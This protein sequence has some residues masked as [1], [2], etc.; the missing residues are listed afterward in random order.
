MEDIPCAHDVEFLEFT[1]FGTRL[2]S[3]ASS[4]AIIPAP[5]SCGS[6]TIEAASGIS[7]IP[8]HH[9]VTV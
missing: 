3:L 9:R 2:P 4:E 8:R 5:Q 7:P 1:A 6:G